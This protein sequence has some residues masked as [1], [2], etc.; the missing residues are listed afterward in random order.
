MLVLKLVGVK[1]MVDLIFIT[2]VGVPV[3]YVN[4]LAEKKNK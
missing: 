1:V 3:F 2:S 4:M